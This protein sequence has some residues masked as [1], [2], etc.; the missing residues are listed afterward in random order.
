MHHVFN[1]KIRREQ[2]TAAMERIR[3]RNDSKMIKAQYTVAYA[4][5]VADPDR[6][7]GMVQRQEH[8]HRFHDSTDV[9]PAEDDFHLAGLRALFLFLRIRIPE[10]VSDA[11]DIEV[12]VCGIAP[13]LDFPGMIAAA[14]ISWYLVVKPVHELFR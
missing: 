2:L 6:K 7:P 4:F 9:L 11:G 5:R 8:F 1:L 13:A 3:V 14:P 10:G 12:D